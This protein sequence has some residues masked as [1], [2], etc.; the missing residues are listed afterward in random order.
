MSYAGVAAAAAFASTCAIPV[1]GPELAPEAATAAAAA[2]LA[3]GALAAFDLGGVVPKTQV[4]MV[5]G[6]ERVLTPSQNSTFEN[7]IKQSSVGGHTFHQEFHMHGVSDP[8]TAAR[9]AAGYAMA[10]IMSKFR[11]GGV[12]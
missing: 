2:T 6:G 4:A 12:R 7:L 9:K 8:E 10:G 3:Y 11:T 1:V 5:H